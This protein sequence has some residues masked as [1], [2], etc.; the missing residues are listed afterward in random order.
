MEGRIS[1]RYPAHLAAAG[2]GGVVSVWMFV[3]T[4]GQ[5]TETRLQSSSGEPSLDRL[6]LELAQEFRFQPARNDQCTLA[7]WIALPVSFGSVGL[8]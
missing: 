1:R 2:I 6:A 5:V 7:V 8:P 3:E 4:S